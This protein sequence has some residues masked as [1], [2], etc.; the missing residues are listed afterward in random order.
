MGGADALNVQGEPKPLKALLKS[1]VPIDRWFAPGQ[2]LR[3]RRRNGPQ[4]E[5][6]SVCLQ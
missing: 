4:D 2:K 3:Y 5:D 6:W 1:T